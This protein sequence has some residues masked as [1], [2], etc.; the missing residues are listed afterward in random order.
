MGRKLLLLAI[1]FSL[2][3][4]SQ[5]CMG[6]DVELHS[7]DGRG[8]AD[9]TST[10]SDVPTDPIPVPPEAP[11]ADA[12]MR[13]VE[14]DAAYR[15]PIHEAYASPLQEQPGPTTALKAAPPAPVNEVVPETRP[16]GQDLTWIKGYWAWD[17]QRDDYVWVS[18]V[19]RRTPEGSNLATW[20]LD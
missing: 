15:G 10:T 11:E 20:L 18:G 7:A 19:W 17:D 13:E 8:I 6:Q 16:E 5:H 2:A 3:F 4:A 9:G 1:V 12:D 14:G